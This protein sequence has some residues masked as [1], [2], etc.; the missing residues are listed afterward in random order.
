MFT[1]GTNEECIKNM[2][3]AVADL[4]QL[5]K[6]LKLK[7]SYTGVVIS[8]VSQAAE[9]LKS[10]L[11]PIGVDYPVADHTKDLGTNFTFSKNFY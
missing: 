2:F 3:N 7:L 1:Y 11:K 10:L 6:Q 8:K 4:V 5:T 9:T